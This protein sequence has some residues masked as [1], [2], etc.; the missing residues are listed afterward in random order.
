MQPYLIGLKHLLTGKVHNKELME[1][2]VR[3]L[4]LM[5]RNRLLQRQ[6]SQLQQETR[7]FFASVMAN[8]ENN[9][10]SQQKPQQLQSNT[11]KSD[12]D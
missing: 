7:S 5:Q 1:I 4:N 3:T 11:S 6:L 2:A 10:N 9:N 8:P 12:Q